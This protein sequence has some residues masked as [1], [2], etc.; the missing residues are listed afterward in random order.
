MRNLKRFLAM[1]LTVLMIAGCFSFASFAEKFD[2]V[3]DYD[4]AIDVLSDLGVI[5]G[6]EDG[7]FGPDDPVERWHMALWIAKMETGK[8]TTDDYLTIWRAEENYTDF[9]D[10]AVDQAIGAINYA[11]DEKIIIGTTPTTFAPTAGITYQDALTMVVR[12]LGFGGK[13]MDAGYPWKYINKAAELGLEKGLS[14]IAYKDVL[15]RAETAQILY[16]ALYAVDADGKTYI[17][18]VFGLTTVIITGTT[19][20]RIIETESVIKTGYV[21]FNVLNGDGSINGD[22][23]Y[24]LPETAFGIEKGKADNYVGASYKVVTDD[25]FKTVKKAIACP[26]KVFDAA[27]I[28]GKGAYNAPSPILTLGEDTYEAVKKYSSLYNEQGIKG[29]IPEILVYTTNLTQPTSDGYFKVDKDYNVLDKDGKI[30]AYYAPAI[31][32]TYQNP[33]AKRLGNG[34][35][36]VFLN[37]SEIIAAG[38]VW[39]GVTLNEYSQTTDTWNLVKNNKYASAKVYDDNCDG[40]YDRL[41]YTYHEFGK[42]YANADTPDVGDDYYIETGL[43]KPSL[44]VKKFIDGATGEALAA[45]PSGYIRYSYDPLSKYLTVYETYTFGTGLVTTVNKAAA[46]AVIGG[47]QYSVGIATYPGAAYDNT[48]VNVNLIGK[49]VNFILA[50]GIVIR[51]FDSAVA[52]NYIVFDNLTGLTSAGYATALA[53]VQSNQASVITIAT[54]NGYSYQNYVLLAEKGSLRST[55]KALDT[56]DLFTGT[57]DALG[58]WH[59]TE[60]KDYTYLAFEPPNK[61][62]HKYDRIPGTDYSDPDNVIYFRNGIANTLDRFYYDGK[63]YGTLKSFAQFNTNANTLYIVYNENKDRFYT[64]KGIPVNGAKILIDEAVFVDTYNDASTNGPTARFVYVYDG[65]L[66]GQYLTNAWQAYEYDTVIY[67]DHNSVKDPLVTNDLGSTGTLLGSTWQYNRVLDMINGKWITVQTAYNLQLKP[68]RFYTVSNGY[69]EDEVDLNEGI[70]NEGLLKEYGIFYSIIEP[71]DGRPDIE[72]SAYT[73]LYKLDGSGNVVFDPNNGNLINYNSG[74]IGVKYDYLPVYYYVGDA[75]GSRVILCLDEASVKGE[76]PSKA[77]YDANKFGVGKNELLTYAYHYLPTK[78]TQTPTS[79]IF[80]ILGADERSAVNYFVVP[81]ALYEALSAC[82]PRNRDDWDTDNYNTYDNWMRIYDSYG[83]EVYNWESDFTVLVD[84]VT[85]GDRVAKTPIYAM[86]LRRSSN[87][88]YSP[89]PIGVYTILFKY[90]NAIYRVY[91]KLQLE[92]LTPPPA[93]VN[94]IA[95]AKVVMYDVDLNNDGIITDLSGGPDTL[96]FYFTNLKAM[97]N[98]DIEI[99]AQVK[100]GAVHTACHNSTAPYQK[101]I[102]VDDVFKADAAGEVVADVINW[103]YELETATNGKLTYGDGK[104]G[105]KCSACDA[106]TDLKFDIVVKIKVVGDDHSARTI[107]AAYQPS[108]VLDADSYTLLPSLQDW[109]YDHHLPINTEI[110]LLT[111]SLLDD[112]VVVNDPWFEVPSEGGISLIDNI[113]IGVKPFVKYGESPNFWGQGIR[114]NLISV[115][116]YGLLNKFV[117]TYPL[118]GVIPVG[119]GTDPYWIFNRDAEPNKNIKMTLKAEDYYSEPGAINFD[120]INFTYVLPF[121]VVFVRE[122]GTTE[123]AGVLGIN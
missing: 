74:D 1:A 114:Y 44:V 109:A 11:A 22:V 17:A 8:V 9:T 43:A 78:M 108:V 98:H 36:T 34:A 110:V 69:V 62:S 105:F 111:A 26:S 32:G 10:V 59:L 45:A 56:G 29:N 117:L 30:V 2:D 71:L 46:K 81:Q 39:Y 68:E 63:N 102:L 19:S 107:A 76:Y 91:V 61:Y 123:E 31:T 18:D 75:R 65:S 103:R 104:W 89:L 87:A 100:D 49:Q 57:K 64:A 38:G 47:T 84:N 66:E 24:H 101:I 95:N 86:A 85:I 14:G 90:N 79:V 83:D 42:I 55:T 12:A 120:S 80:R 121:E 3:Y 20:Y 21:S 92:D 52:T 122:L 60:I 106:I 23:T 25:N 35:Y 93:Y 118:D 37:N 67:V 40:V 58:F 15:T 70:I 94:P 27:D 5:W 97:D 33:Y 116:N 50:D 77:E 51:V 99:Y 4:D 7:T 48:G 112:N 82:N 28:V 113:R 13:I 53:Y 96:R 54:I 119:S 41:F 6:Y 88:A 73:Y 115:L 16:N 72:Y